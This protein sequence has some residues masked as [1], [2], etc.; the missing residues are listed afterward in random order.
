MTNARLLKDILANMLIIGF[1]F[2]WVLGAVFAKGFVSTT[3]ASF[4]PPWGWYL[5]VEKLAVY[6][7]W[8]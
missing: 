6:W 5:I 4:F 2:C 8:I 1:L 3:I 7:G